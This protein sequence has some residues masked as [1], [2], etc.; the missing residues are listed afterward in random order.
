M[1]TWD[2][3]E[4]SRVVPIASHR[5]EDLVREAA[6][7]RDCVKQ[8]LLDAEALGRGQSLAHE[9]ARPADRMRAEAEH[10]R[11]LRDWC[12]GYYVG[13]LNWIADNLSGATGCNLDAERVRARILSLLDAVEAR[14]RRS[15]RRRAVI[16]PIAA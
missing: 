13:S 5:R 11:R 3:P 14:A 7:W 8:A 12:Y 2:T 4:L 15:K 10:A 6:M 16:V 1:A 9:S